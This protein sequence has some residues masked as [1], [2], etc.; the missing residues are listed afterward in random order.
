MRQLLFALM[1]VVFFASCAKDD[2]SLEPSPM[3]AIDFSL[4]ALIDD[5]LSLEPSQLF[6]VKKES[7]AFSDLGPKLTFGGNVAKGE[8]GT[9]S[10]NGVEVPQTK[11]GRWY[12]RITSDNAS[13]FIAETYTLSVDNNKAVLEDVEV[14][15]TS[16]GGALFPGAKITWTSKAAEGA[17]TLLIFKQSSITEAGEIVEKPVYEYEIVSGNSFTVSESLLKDFSNGDEVIVSVG[18]ANVVSQ[19]SRVYATTAIEHSATFF[20]KK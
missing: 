4:R 14:D 12:R 20:V 15:L 10:V 17:S 13:E 19:D 8:V 3:D 16:V 11:D 5:P 7:N 18:I 1:G 9:F 2:A 6:Y